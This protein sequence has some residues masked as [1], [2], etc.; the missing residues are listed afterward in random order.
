MIK[1]TATTLQL[2]IPQLMTVLAPQPRKYCEWGRGTGKSTIIAWRIKDI[3]TQMPRSSN[4][5]VG[6][7]YQQILT[8]TLPSTISS[9]ERLGFIK[10][11]HYFVGRKP[12]KAWNWPEPFEPPLNYDHFIIFYTGAGFHLVSQDRPGSGRGLNTDS[13]TG[14][15]M[16]LLDFERLFN[17]VLATN[18]GN[19][20]RFGKCPLHHSEFFAGTVPM[21]AK[22]KWVIKMEEEAR[23]NPSQVFY[24]R[25]SAEHNRHN[26]GEK[27]F[28]DNKR[29]LPS[30]IYN[31]EILNIRPDKVEG[32]FYGKL[33][34]KQHTYVAY[35][36]SHLDNVGYESP[37]LD[38]RQDSDLNTNAPIDLSIDYGAS[39]NVAVIA[40]EGADNTYRFINCMY[41]KHPLRL[42][43]L[44]NDFCNYY[45]YHKNRLIN[46]YYDH[47]AVGTD[48]T[49]TTTYADEVIRLLTLKGW[50]VVKKYIGQAPSHHSKYLLWGA[51]LSGDPRIPRILLNRSN[52]S[53]LLISML[54]APVRQGRNGF[55]K[56]KSSERNPNIDQAEATHPSDA[57]D[58]LLFGKYSGTLSHHSPYVDVITG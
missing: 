45:A 27:F 23:E 20:D 22:G 30:L 58:T 54:Q 6:E 16:T 25:A 8:R 32:G 44:L 15:E 35:N 51:A 56:D 53:T 29:R 18:R 41:V 37:H 57:A 5:I 9:L 46:Y 1:E 49:R 34:E 55:E 14:D 50:N 47:T 3:V 17:D 12:P 43:D 19:L 24:L 7:T 48:A 10:D 39:I 11:Q 13:V 40:Q 4:V 2:N 33:S 26:L 52:A 36:Y 31:A 38:C 28:T 21:T 42:E